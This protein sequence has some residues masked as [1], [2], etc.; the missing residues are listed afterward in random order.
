MESLLAELV[1]VA[2]GIDPVVVLGIKGVL[3]VASDRRSS[4]L[5]GVYNAKL[6]AFERD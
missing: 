2:A 3:A 4:S 5:A 6:G 1:V